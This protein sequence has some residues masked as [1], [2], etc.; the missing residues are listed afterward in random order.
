MNKWLTPTVL[1]VALLP[2]VG[3]MGAL[4]FA[5]WPDGWQAFCAHQHLVAQ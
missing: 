1:R 2:I 4:V 5:F 3:A